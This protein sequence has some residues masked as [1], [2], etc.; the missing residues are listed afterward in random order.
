MAT[1]SIKLVRC[2]GKASTGLLDG[3]SAFMPVPESIPQEEEEI[4]SAGTHE[5]TTIASSANYIYEF[6]D[7]TV[8]GGAVR[9]VAG[10][11]PEATDS[12]GWLLLDGSNRQ[13]SV[14]VASEKL[15]IIDAA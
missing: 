10:T 9:M 6:W 15:S 12:T 11:T 13:F 1:V 14:S 8:S 2:S 3:A 4:T 5:V 7:I